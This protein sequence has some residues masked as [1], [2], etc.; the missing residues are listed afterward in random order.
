[1]RSPEKETE[2]DKVTHMLYVK[3]GSSSENRRYKGT[4][5]RQTFLLG[6]ERGHDPARYRRAELS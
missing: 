1:M 6:S 4:Q 5:V 3:Q 2:E